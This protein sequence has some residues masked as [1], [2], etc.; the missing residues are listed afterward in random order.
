MRR[1][2]L[3]GKQPFGLELVR[4]SPSSGSVLAGP[5]QP[6]SVLLLGAGR[7]H[8]SAH[9]LR[10]TKLSFARSGERRH[11]SV[12]VPPLLADRIYR[13]QDER[14]G[15]PVIAGHLGSGTR[16]VPDSG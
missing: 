8:V 16:P 4:L 5:A 11:A 7:L 3:S 14:A 1:L 15:V 12:L 13:R 2:H 6:V 9:S 10:W